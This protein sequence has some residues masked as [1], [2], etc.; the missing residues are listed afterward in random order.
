MKLPN[1]NLTSTRQKQTLASVISTSIRNWPAKLVFV[2][3]VLLTAIACEAPKEIGLAPST[4][5]DVLY[6]DT[7]TITRTTI[8]LDSVRSNDQSSALI[9]RYADPIFGQIESKAFIQLRPSGSLVVTDSGTSNVTSAD[10]IIV[11][12]TKLRFPINSIWYGDTTATHEVIL[13]ELTDSLRSINY[14]IS[15]PGPAVSKVIARRTFKPRPSVVDTAGY[16][17]PTAIANTIGS[18]ILSMANTNALLFS[19]TTGAWV[20]PVA[21]R[22]KIPHD[23]VLTSNSVP[24]ASILGMTPS[25][26]AVIT[27]FHVKGETFARAYTLPFIGKRFNQITANRGGTALASLRPGQSLPTTVTGRSYV[28]PATGVTTKLQFPS[29]LGLLSSGRIAI[30]RA[31][32][33]V[34]PNVAEDGKRPLPPYLVLSEVNA[35]NRLARSVTTTG[36]ESILFTVQTY[37]PSDR[38]PASFSGTQTAILDP[39][40]NSYTFQLAGYL[41]SV[42]SK[43]SPNNGL[44]ILTPSSQLFVQNAQTGG[45]TDQTQAV[46]SN[47]VWRMVLDGKASVKLVLFYTKSN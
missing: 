19:T 8:Q 1:T 41:Q 5:V 28:Q 21:F 24:Q 39:R 34:T 45:L 4:P 20:D 3:A 40:T 16:L 13:S 7:M 27:Y 14:D 38:L 25:E 31:D 29:L 35:Q 44:A 23:Y 12:S 42:A 43:V 11:D 22:Q 17:Y 6:T 33:I 30:N 15:S 32:L 2:A 46:L 47:R 9:G 36:I 10:R 26:G 37:G 18:T